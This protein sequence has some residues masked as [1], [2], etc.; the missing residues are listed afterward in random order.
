MKPRARSLGAACRAPPAVLA[1]AR[2]GL[3]AM[4]AP[5][6]AGLLA[7]LTAACGAGEGG[8]VVR[9][10]GSSSLYPLSVAV[11]DDLAAAR[12]DARIVVA[13]SGTAGGLR[14]LCEGGIDV[15]GASRPISTAE[16]AL[17]R[18]AGIDYLAIPVARDGIAIVVNAANTV[19]ECLT[20]G[21]L[22]RLWEPSSPVR[23]WRDLRPA[24]PAETIRLFGPGSDSG[25]FDFF[26]N[27]VVGRPGASRVDYYQTEDNN[28]IAR[29]IAGD[30]WA[31]GYLGSA[32]TATDH[33]VLRTVAV[34]TGFGCVLPTGEAVS[35]GRYSPLSRDLYLYVALGSLTRRDVYDFV[36]HYVASTARLSRMTGFVALPAAEYG[37]GLDLL[38]RTRGEAP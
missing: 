20:L 33:T 17:C 1:A 8:R 22:A 7:V 21:E 10:G 25:T 36:H 13:K 29:G 37:R 4:F 3:P 19:L 24:L 38:A 14:R 15:S 35:D 26:T 2:R 6:C 32:A 18:A 23:R 5:A 11:A 9:V 30:R 16:A 31:L 34:D 28:L 12:P 27:V